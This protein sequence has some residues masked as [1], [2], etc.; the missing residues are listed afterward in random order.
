MSA[1]RSTSACIVAAATS[2]PL[3]AGEPAA[4]CRV[5]LRWR[6][7]TGFLNP[8]RLCT[9]DPR[10]REIFAFGNRIQRCDGLH[11]DAHQLTCPCEHTRYRA[12]LS[13]DALGDS[14]SVSTRPRVQS[15]SHLIR[16]WHQTRRFRRSTM[17]NRLGACP[18]CCQHL[19]RPGPAAF[20]H[21]SHRIALASPL[22]FDSLSSSC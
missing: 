10:A 12:D 14:V 9:P 16:P 22:R 1:T 19:S 8:H 21:C 11:T 13:P 5:A 7:P 4:T 2:N 6:I 15:G 18:R 17:I 3:R 20:P